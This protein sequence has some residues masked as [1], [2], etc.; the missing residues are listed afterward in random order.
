MSFDAIQQEVPNLE[1]KELKELI[2]C[3]MSVLQRR[4]D[5]DFPARMTRL[6][7]DTTPGRWLTLEEAEKRLGIAP[8]AE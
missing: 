4:Q 7:D 6:I 5:P 2:G 3:A 8:S 1:T